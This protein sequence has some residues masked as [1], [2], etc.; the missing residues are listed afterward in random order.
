MSETSKS[1]CEITIFMCRLED[2]EKYLKGLKPAD[3]R[4]EELNALEKEN[5]E[6]S[7]GL[8]DE[9]E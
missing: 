4:M 5:E 6:L 8:Y 3:D 1:Y 7:K 9:A 2:K